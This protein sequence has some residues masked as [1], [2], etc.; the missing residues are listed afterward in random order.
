MPIIVKDWK[1][2]H[3]DCKYRFRGCINTDN[4]S[5]IWKNGYIKKRGKCSREHCPLEENNND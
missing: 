3:K 4:K 2:E 5:I 1:E